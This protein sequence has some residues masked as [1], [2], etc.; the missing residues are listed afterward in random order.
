MQ[1]AFFSY[2]FNIITPDTVVKSGYKLLTVLEN[3]IFQNVAFWSGN[4][5]VWYLTQETFLF[6]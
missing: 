1:W 6:S 2:Y 4:E 5:T 3:E